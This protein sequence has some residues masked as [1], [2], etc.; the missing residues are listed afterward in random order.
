MKVLQVAYTFAPDPAGGTEVYVE[1]LSRELQRLGVESTVAAPASADGSYVHRGVLVRR[2]ASAGPSRLEQLYGDGD[3]TAAAAFER[4][5]ED[6][7]PGLVHQHAVSPACSVALMRAAE[8]RGLPVVFTYHTPAVS[9]ARGTLLRW[10]REVC[11]GRLASAPCVSCTLDGLGAGRVAR[12]AAGAVPARAGEWLGRAGL[13]GGAWTAARMP[14]LMRR[15]HARVAEVLSIPARIVALTPWVAALLEAN[16][17]PSGR[18]VNLPHGTAAARRRAPTCRVGPCRF[19]HLGRLDPA[20]GTALLLA[21]MRG[22][23]GTPCELDVVGVAQGEAGRAARQRLETMAAADPRVRFLD[24]VDPADVVDRLAAY[25]MV[26]VPSQWLETGPLVVLEA[27]AAGVPVLGSALGG[28]R[29]LVRDD[30]DGLLV[31]PFDAVSRW[32]DVLQRVALDRALRDRL[33]AGVRRPRTM[34][35][36]AIEM[37]GVYAEVLEGAQTSRAA[38]GANAS[39]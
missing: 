21:A 2:F 23:A 24:P 20:K 22:M 14:A 1:A 37:Q 6:E 19:V 5:L 30:V 28:L 4:L 39:T 7:Q 15:H 32:T 16:G 10:G 33:R 12:R 18:V 11:D 3:P 8:R 36:V 9:C 26:V 25:D 31:D 13:R 34:Q 35:A 27:F 38:D 17:V 29:A